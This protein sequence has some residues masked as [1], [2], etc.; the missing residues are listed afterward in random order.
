LSVTTKT[1]PSLWIPQYARST[2]TWWRFGI[3]N[4]TSSTFGAAS[5]TAVPMCQ[6]V[7]CTERLSSWCANARTSAS[8]QASRSLAKSSSGPAYRHRAS[9]SVARIR[10]SVS[11]KIVYRSLRK[12]PNADPV[13]FNR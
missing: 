3:D 12:P 7:C 2:A 5:S 11:G 8:R 13:V 10:S 9:S 4:V 6:R 1:R